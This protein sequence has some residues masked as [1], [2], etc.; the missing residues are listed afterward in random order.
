MAS[1]DVKEIVD[2]MDVDLSAPDVKLYAAGISLWLAG[3]LLWNV[4]NEWCGAVRA[5]RGSLPP[6]AAPLTQLHGYWHITGGYVTYMHIVF[7]IKRRMDHKKRG[8][9]FALRWIGLGIER[10]DGDS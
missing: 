8:T 10:T 5:L 2:T 3:F 6:A 7:C 1:F 9:A 4:D